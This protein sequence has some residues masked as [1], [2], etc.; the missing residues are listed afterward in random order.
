MRRCDENP[1]LNALY[2]DYK[3]WLTSLLYSRSGCI[4]T[5]SDL[6][7]DVYVRLL[8]KSLLPDIKEPRA[9]LARIAHGLLVDHRRREAVERAWAEMMAAMPE[10]LEPSPE[11]QLVIVDAL[12]RIDAL[13]EGLNPRVRKV[14]LL[15]RVSGMNYADIAKHLSVSLSTV[16]KDIAKA[17]RHCY[18]VLMG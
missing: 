14:F 11:E 10:P 17:L 9:Y 18:V 2:V 13:L 12:V 15:S 8:G 1:V 7:H 16:E 3:D 4:H 5:A 6:C